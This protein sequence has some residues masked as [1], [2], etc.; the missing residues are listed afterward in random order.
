MQ[1]VMAGVPNES[2][3]MLGDVRA[4]EEEITM[5]LTEL[6]ARWNSTKK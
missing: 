3:K 1:H 6:H 4:N 5:N 2:V